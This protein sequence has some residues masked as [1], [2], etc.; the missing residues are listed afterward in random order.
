MRTRPI[1]IALTLIA[2]AI[3]HAHDNWPQFRG[4]NADGK[5]DAKGLPT[6]WSDT[7]HVKW[8]TPVHGKAWSCPVV[9]GKQ[10]WLTTATKDGKQLSV[11][12]IDRDSGK[13]EK[14]AILFEVEKPQFCH[15]FNSYASPTP[16]LEQGRIY[17]TF[18]SPGTAC[19]DTKTG[20][21]I[22][23]RRDFVCN[24]Y[25][26]AGSSP[27]VYGNLLI[28][29]F[30]GSDFQFVVALDKATGHTVWKTDRAIDFQD[31]VN[32]KP[33]SDG[34]WRKAFSTPRIANFDGRD[35]LLSLGSK[36]LYAYDPQTGKDIWRVEE[37]SNHS[38]SSQPCVADGLIYSCMG[39]PKSTKATLLAIKPD[40]MTGILDDSHIVWRGARNVPQKPS[41]IVDNGLL[42]MIDDG[43]IFS[44]LDAK[45]G[46]EFWRERV[47]GNYSASPLLI[48]GKLYVFNEEGKCAV[49]AASREFRKLAESTLPDGVMATPAIAGKAMFLRT[50]TALYRIEE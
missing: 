10:V 34:D 20:E 12:Q 8:K 2:N 30:D 26:G 46:Q 4:P 39:F 27:V 7:D 50:K 37:R 41:V 24:H 49:L 29:N 40:K 38:G 13:I 18:G 33:D 17:V 28:M 14:D 48:D 3:C 25:R 21:K 45:T 22:W 16:V 44:C 6:T 23:E 35:I 11:V 1:L 43:G 47:Q 42:Y 31:L 36:A 15:D 32:G 5:S 9:L 19:V